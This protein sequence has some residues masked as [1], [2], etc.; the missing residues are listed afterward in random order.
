MTSCV[1]FFLENTT[2]KFQRPAYTYYSV[3]VGNIATVQLQIFPGIWWPIIMKIDRFWRSYLNNNNKLRYSRDNA[4]RRLL[5]RSRSLT[6]TD[7]CA[8]RKLECGNECHLCRVGRPI[9]PEILG[10]TGPVCVIQYGMWVP[11]AVMAGLPAGCK[12]L[13]PSLLY[14]TF[15]SEYTN[16]HPISYTVLQL[17]TGGASV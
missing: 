17:S 11:V 15:I 5:R 1:G 13:Y 7:F 16:R 14:F 12:L 10:E 9:V 8:S 6:V 3:E 2:S 4:R